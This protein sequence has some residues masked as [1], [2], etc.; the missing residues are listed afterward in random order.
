MPLYILRLRFM[1][2]QANPVVRQLLVYQWQT[3]D[4]EK[5]T[6]IINPSVQA[7]LQILKSALSHGCASSELYPPLSSLSS[8]SRKNIKRVVYTSSTGAIR[9][10]APVEA[11]EAVTKIYSEKDWNNECIELIQK[12]GKDALSTDK[13]QASKVLAERGR[14]LERSSV[15]SDH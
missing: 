3:K 1:M 15:L 14:C 12:L 8:T 11:P 5:K 7:T 4:A 6:E 10:S 9:R 2:R 13:Y